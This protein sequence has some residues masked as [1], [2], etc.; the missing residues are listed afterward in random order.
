MIKGC[1][2]G[3]RQAFKQLYELYKSDMFRVCRVYAPNYEIANDFLQ[4]GF[5]KVFQNLH[6]YQ[7]GKSLGGWMRRVMINNSID[8]LRRDHWDKIVVTLK[9]DYEQ[10]D[11]GNLE[12]DF[13]RR[14]NSSSFFEILDKIPLGYKTV[15]NL[16]YVEGLTHKEI[17]DKLGIHA[18]SSKSQLSKAKKYL[19]SILLE[20]MSINEIEDYVGQ[21]ARE[22]V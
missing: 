12:N 13:E 22:V 6:K 8:M 1:L 9:D 11:P 20:E 7:S 16:H 17:S 19:R 14:L 5:L 2:K 10:A 21:L 4:E 3:K 15:L 18:G